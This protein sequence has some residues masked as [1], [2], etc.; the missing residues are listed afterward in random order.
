MKGPGTTEGTSKIPVKSGTRGKSLRD[1]LA[2]LNR[3]RP[4]PKPKPSEENPE[5]SAVG[6]IGGLQERPAGL[7]VFP[8]KG[9]VTAPVVGRLV[10]RYGQ[11]L[12]FG[13]TAKGLRVYTRSGAQIVAPHDGQI[14][15]AGLFR[16]HGLILI[17]EH[18]GGYHTVL[19]GFEHVDVVTGQTC[20]RQVFEDEALGNVFQTFRSA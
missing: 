2:K 19:A 9:P 16:D 10:Q 12:G 18:P 7:K 3:A 17:I 11:D 20:A 8:A 6:G 15:F 14:V 4:K 5:D 1:L 13:Q